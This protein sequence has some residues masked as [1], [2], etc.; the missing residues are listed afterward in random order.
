MHATSSIQINGNGTLSMHSI[1]IIS[2]SFTIE[3]SI[4]I[5]FVFEN[6][7]RV[8]NA[9]VNAPRKQSSSFTCDFLLLLLLSSLYLWL[10]PLV[11]IC[12]CSGRYILS[13]NEVRKHTQ[14]VK[15]TLPAPQLFANFQCKSNKLFFEF[16]CGVFF[17]LLL[18]CT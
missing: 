6:N 7:R 12:S 14:R 13:M 15:N 8:R 16:E 4:S 11:R 17:Y 5:I 3:N 9:A 18:F 1:S 10:L 2:S